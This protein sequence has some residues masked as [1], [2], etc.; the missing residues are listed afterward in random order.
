[1]KHYF[2]KITSRSEENIKGL[3]KEMLSSE[4]SKILLSEETTRH[5]KQGSSNWFITINSES[6]ILSKEIVDA[7][8][9]VDGKFV[10]LWFTIIEDKINCLFTSKGKIDNKITITDPEEV[11]KGTLDLLKQNLNESGF[12]LN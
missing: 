6:E 10:I 8:S 4:V 2:Y 5:H 7:T 12:L 11:R 1:M 3:A 9:R